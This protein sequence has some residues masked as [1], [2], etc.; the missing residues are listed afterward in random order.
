M[1][2]NGANEKTHSKKELAYINKLMSH[3][4]DKTRAEWYLNAAK[5]W[6]DGD[7]ENYVKYHLEMFGIKEE[8]K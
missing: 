3:G 1:K 6:T 8:V 5:T 7:Y 2:K 4:M